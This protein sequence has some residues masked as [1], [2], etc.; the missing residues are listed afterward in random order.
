[1]SL[2]LDVE[3]DVLARS[4]RTDVGHVD[5]ARFEL[6]LFVANEAIFQL[7]YTPGAIGPPGAES[8]RHRPGE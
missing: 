5:V 7:I 2:R 3:P 8:R 1:M 6:R 4:H